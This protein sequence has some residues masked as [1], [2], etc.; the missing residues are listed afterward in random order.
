MIIQFKFNDYQS[1][2]WHLL[3][4]V[5]IDLDCLEWEPWVVISDHRSVSPLVIHTK[6]LTFS[7]LGL[8]GIVVIGGQKDNHNH[9]G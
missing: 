3:F 8:L 6:S 1:F 5:A 2:Q 7:F 4:G 9:N